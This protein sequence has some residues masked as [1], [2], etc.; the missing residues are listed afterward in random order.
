MVH[1]S[2]NNTT[3]LAFLF[4]FPCTFEF[5]YPIFPSPTRFVLQASSPASLIISNQRTLKRDVQVLSSHYDGALM[6]GLTLGSTPH[7][8]V[9]PAQATSCKRRAE[10]LDLRRPCRRRHAADRDAFD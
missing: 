2:N 10:P 6:A 7:S 5:T 8:R 4:I 3:S 9:L 1:S